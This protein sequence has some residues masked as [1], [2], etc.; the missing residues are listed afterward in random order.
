MTFRSKVKEE[1][2]QELRDFIF[3]YHSKIVDNTAKVTN[4]VAT[5]TNKRLARFV[6]TDSNAVLVSIVDNDGYPLFKLEF[7]FITVDDIDY[8]AIK[9]SEVDGLGSYKTFAL[10]DTDGIENFLVQTIK[11]IPSESYLKHFLNIFKIG[12]PIWLA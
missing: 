1:L 2:F 9:Y 10:T 3:L 8:V 11:F 4:I 6:T 12:I 5:L 7:Y